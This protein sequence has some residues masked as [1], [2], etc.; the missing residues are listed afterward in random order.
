MVVA[1]TPTG[2]LPFKLS[3]TSAD[4]SVITDTDIDLNSTSAFTWLL[5]VMPMRAAS[6]VITLEL[7]DS[8]GAT[9]TA[10][11]TVTGLGR[12]FHAPDY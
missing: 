3:A 12:H 11:F 1:A 9:S 4:Q 7:V 2:A 6:T 8:A 5:R 10:S